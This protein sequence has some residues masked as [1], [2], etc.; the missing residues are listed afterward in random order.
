V[1]DTCWKCCFHSEVTAA[2][3]EQEVTAAELEHEE[4]TTVEQEQDMTT[5]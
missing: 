3:Q 2:W 1:L 5:T 4:V